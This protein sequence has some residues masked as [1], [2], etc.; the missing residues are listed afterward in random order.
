MPINQFTSYFLFHLYSPHLYHI[1]NALVRRP[2]ITHDERQSYEHTSS[3]VLPV[4]THHHAPYQDYST[5]L[6][7]YFLDEAPAI[8]AVLRDGHC[9]DIHRDSLDSDIHHLRL[10]LGLGVDRRRY[11]GRHRR[12][13]DRRHRVRHCT[14]C[15]RHDQ[16]RLGIL[17]RHCGLDHCCIVCCR[18]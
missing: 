2:R 15:T 7:R 13:L 6:P 18:R 17:G 5:T 16:D 4:G 14:R 3:G 11:H 1:F 12:F 8:F 10:G 9:N